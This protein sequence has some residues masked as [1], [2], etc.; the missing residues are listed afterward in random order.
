VHDCSFVSLGCGGVLVVRFAEQ[1]FEIP[2]EA[3][4]TIYEIGPAVES[5][6]VEVSSDGVTWTHVGTYK[7]G[8]TVV[9]ISGYAN[10]S[11][12]FSYVRITDVARLPDELYSGADIDAVSAIRRVNLVDAMPSGSA[13]EP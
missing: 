5:I 2:D 10:P 7:G 8:K 11:Q 4:I 12:G 13:A 6:G 9:D 3:E 1:F